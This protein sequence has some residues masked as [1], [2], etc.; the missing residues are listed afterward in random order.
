MRSDGLGKPTIRQRVERFL[1]WT[2]SVSALLLVAVIA[3]VSFA[4]LNVRGAP[5]GSVSIALACF[6]AIG[7]SL[8]PPIFFRLPRAVKFLSFGGLI[9]A[10]FTVLYF[11]NQA[12]DAY[13]RTPEGAKVAAERAAKKKAEAERQQARE[14]I[15]GVVAQHNEMV[16][17][18]EACLDSQEQVPALS[19]AVKEAMHN[20]NSFEHVYTKFLE[21]NAEGRNIVIRFR[22][23]NGFGGVITSEVLGTIDPDTCSV[24]NLTKAD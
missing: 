20:P 8:S 24:T 18:L 10:F 19:D 23:T 1:L 15:E 22:G 4:Q 2:V 16:D 6:A 11:T 21:T 7:I 3:L 12:L 5:I 13:E 9:V 17:K 14:I